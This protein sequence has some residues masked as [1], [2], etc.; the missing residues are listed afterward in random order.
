[1]IW[2]GFMPGLGFMP[3]LWSSDGLGV[4]LGLWFTL[5]LRRNEAG[6][7]FIHGLCVRQG[8]GEGGG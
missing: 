4:R 3:S 5:G 6:V 7:W 8:L 1:M 2:S